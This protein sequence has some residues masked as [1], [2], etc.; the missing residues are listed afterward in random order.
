MLDCFLFRD[1]PAFSGEFFA[2]LE[3]IKI[4]PD[5]PIY[6]QNNFRRAICFVLS[7]TAIA[8]SGG[9]PLNTFGTGDCFGAAA[10]FSD[11]SHYVSD[12]FAKSACEVVFISDNQLIDLFSHSPQAA[13]SYIKF[14]SDRIR[15]LNRKISNFTMPTIQ[16]NLLRHLTL[17]AV[18][19][20]YEVKASY[21]N[22][23][24]ELSIGRASL[25]R[26]MRKLEEEGVISRDGKKITLLTSD[27]I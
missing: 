27:F 23:A 3:V 25:Y 18:D 5:H 24:K 13:V 1:I 16:K 17:N 26:V 15:F 14:L 20:V 8:R 22:L 7:G 9:V 12:V 4:P 2:K 21:L 10:L 6:T 19:R 11:E